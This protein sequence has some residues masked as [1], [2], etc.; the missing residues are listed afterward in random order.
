MT[1]L[2]A[3]AAGRSAA[4]TELAL[5]RDEIHRI[6]QALRSHEHDLDLRE[7][8][9][10]QSK[11]DADRVS[12]ERD[13][14]ARLVDQ[15]RGELARVGDN[16][17]EFSDQKRELE[18]AL[19]EA[20]ARAK[21]LDLAERQAGLQVLVMRDVSLSLGG[22]VTA[23]RAAVTAIGGKPAVRL[24]AKDAFGA[25]LEITKAGTSTLERLAEVVR[26]HEHARVE[27]SDLSADGASPEDRILRL[28]R[29]A[30]VLV[31]K[32]LGFERIG[33]AVVPMAS[34][35]PSDPPGP[36]AKDGPTSPLSAEP[37]GGAAQALTWREGPG[38]LELVIDV[39]PG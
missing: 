22:D 2:H 12:T 10:A 19:N 39:G 15:L 26:S 14:A 29:V 7:G 34:S 6:G 1:T 4:E 24:A 28:Q 32:G 3:E 21:R 13:D 35:A 20:D 17:R 36:A 5:A 8:E 33:F 18:S 31:G 38:S 37:G 11:L 16:L 23:G 27:L 30:D 9:L 25:D